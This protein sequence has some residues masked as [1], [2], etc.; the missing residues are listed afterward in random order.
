MLL[1]I[2]LFIGTFFSPVISSNIYR[3]FNNIFHEFKV[4]KKVIITEMFN[5]NFHNKFIKFWIILFIQ[6]FLIYM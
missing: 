3:Y 6:L 5:A 2:F 1:W 4:M